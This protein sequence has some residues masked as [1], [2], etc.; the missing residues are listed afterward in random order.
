MERKTRQMVTDD[1]GRFVGRAEELSRLSLWLQDEAAATRMFSITGMGGIGKSSLMSRLSGLGKDAGC[2]CLWLDGRSF[3]P[4][5]ASFLE[6]LS[7]AVSL[8]QLEPAGSN[9]LQILSKSGV[10]SRV[11][12]FIDNFEELSLLEGWLLEAFLPK[13]PS[14]GVAVLLAS[15]PRLPL[16]WITHPVWGPR[17]TE[18]R[19]SHFTNEEMIDYIQSFGT[20]PDEAIGRLAR[21]SDGHPLAL[22]LSVEAAIKD[23]AFGPEKQIISQSISARVLRELASEKLQ[24]MVDVLTVLPEANQEMLSRLTGREVTLQQF[25]ELA[26]L[27]FIRSGTG[28]LGLHDVAR[29]HLLR[30]FRQREPER[31]RELQCSAAQLLHRRLQ[32]ADRKQRRGIASQMLLLSKDLLSPDRGYADFSGDSIPPLEQPAASDLPDLHKMLEEWCAYSIDPPMHRTY[33]EFLDE[34]A[35]RFPESIA[36]VRDD[37]GK[38]AGMFIIMLVYDETGT[39]LQRYFPH[40]LSECFPEEE[41]NCEPDKADTYYPVLA[42]ATN[43][44][45]GYSR[46]EI[47]GLLMLGHLS[48]LGDGSRAVLIATNDVLKQQLRGIGF[49]MRPTATRNCDVSWAEAHILELDFRADNFGNWVLSFFKGSAEREPLFAEVF[50]ALNPE[51]QERQLRKILLSLHDPVELENYIGMFP[52]VDSGVELQR[53]MLRFLKTP[54][55]Y[56]PTKEYVFLLYAAYWQHAGNPEAAAFEC[57]MSRATFYR[58]LKK[59][60]ANFARVLAAQLRNGGPEPG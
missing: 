43:A 59:A 30:D 38:P 25:R 10:L 39:L 1:G 14:A 44:V 58:H 57:S 19:L 20:F 9:P 7:A 21:I 56:G 6:N 54:D 52:G 31:L 40:E 36:I 45:P 51:D 28:G 4:T 35:V 55:E 33:H 42:A 47:I 50:H 48:L 23:H 32:Q 41:W 3:T 2:T 12:L 46:E 11:M 5:P 16:S 27:S 29:M 34:L 15:R 18:F 26:G 24:P 17:L 22:A 8:E 13:L 60:V 49:R 53:W 37:R